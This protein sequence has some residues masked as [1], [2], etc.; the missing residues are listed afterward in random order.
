MET[1]ASSLVQWQGKS[2]ARALA[3][4]K[5]VLKLRPVTSE[6]PSRVSSPT[7]KALMELS[8]DVKH[9]GVP[10]GVELGVVQGLLRAFIEKVRGLDWSHVTDERAAA[11]AAFDLA[12]LLRLGGKSASELAAD[13]TVKPLL[14]RVSCPQFLSWASSY[15]YREVA[16]HPGSLR[17]HGQARV[18]RRGTSAPHATH[19]RTANEASARRGVAAA[20]AQCGTAEARR[21][22]ARPSVWN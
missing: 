4:L 20:R 12:F 19:P 14:E 16:D 9:L 15:E 2:I 21:A 10:P 17:P 1:H 5:P 3:L 8:K 18:P 22:A 7:T 11:Q 13:A 6:L